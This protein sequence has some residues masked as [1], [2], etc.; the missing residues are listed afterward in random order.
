MIIGDGN[1]P[2]DDIRIVYTD[3]QQQP[4]AGPPITLKSTLLL[5]VIGLA[6]LAFIMGYIVFK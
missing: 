4:P 6:A 5:V 2:S 1:D 3:K